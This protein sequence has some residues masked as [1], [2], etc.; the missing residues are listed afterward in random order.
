MEDN[1]TAKSLFSNYY[2]ET[3]LRTAWTSFESFEVESWS[4]DHERKKEINI[5]LLPSGTTRLDFQTTC[6]LHY[7][8]KSVKTKYYDREYKYGR[9]KPVR[10]K[11]RNLVGK[12]G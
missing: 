1:V 9:T 11:L 2:I 7:K 12:R 5:W 6:D 8:E 4:C 3:L 10:N